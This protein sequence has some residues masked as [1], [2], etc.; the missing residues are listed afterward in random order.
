MWFMKTLLLFLLVDINAWLIMCGLTEILI[1]R[2]TT[3]ALAAAMQLQ[4][5]L[6]TLQN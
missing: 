1:M 4:S 2:V 3:L 6:K 5:L